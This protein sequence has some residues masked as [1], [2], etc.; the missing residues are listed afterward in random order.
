LRASKLWDAFDLDRDLARTKYAGQVVEVTA[1]GKVERDQD[2]KLYF[3]AQV[4]Q[5]GTKPA[6][7]LTAQEQRWEKNGYP[8]NVRCYLTPGQ[9]A[10]LAD[11]APGQECV[12]R[13]VC[14]GRRDDPSVY[15]GYVVVLENCEVAKAE[16]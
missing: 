6:N 3:G 13:G 16:Q 14:V 9:A 4:V 15:M 10:T 8:A 1:P 7:R 2:G 5:P 12:V 11:L